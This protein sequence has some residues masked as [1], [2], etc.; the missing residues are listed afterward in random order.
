M[1]ES[2]STCCVDSRIKQRYFLSWI[3][4]WTCVK[5]CTAVTKQVL[6]TSLSP[7][8]KHGIDCHTHDPTFLFHVWI[9]TRELRSCSVIVKDTTRWRLFQMTDLF[10]K[11]PL[12]CLYLCLSCGSCLSVELLGLSPAVFRPMS[13]PATVLARVDVCIAR[14]VRAISFLVLV[15]T[16]ALPLAFL[17]ESTC[18]LLSS[19]APV[20]FP[21]DTVGFAPKFREE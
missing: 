5:L 21:A 8:E 11:H 12:V 20:P 19:S 18:I 17:K 10:P 13:S 4:D 3:L 6:C 7:C 14:V 16:C 2:T 15:L 9:Y 1:L